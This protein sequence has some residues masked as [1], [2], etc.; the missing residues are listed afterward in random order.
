MAD[1]QLAGEPGDA[2]VGLSGMKCQGELELP[3]LSHFR[4]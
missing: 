3:K 2:G 1:L 4:A